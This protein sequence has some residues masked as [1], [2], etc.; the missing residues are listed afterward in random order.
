MEL[1]DTTLPAKNLFWQVLNDK[2]ASTDA[3]MGYS[4]ATERSALS[5]KMQ[6]FYTGCCVV[7]LVFLHRKNGH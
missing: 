2:P 4:Y 5:F 3:N 7:S 1:T 6:I